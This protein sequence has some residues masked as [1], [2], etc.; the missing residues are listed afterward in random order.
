MKPKIGPL[1]GAILALRRQLRETQRG[2][3]NRLGASLRAYSYWE[4]GERTP[5]GGWLARLA[6]IAEREAAHK[7]DM[8][9]LFSEGKADMLQGRPPAWRQVIAAEAMAPRSINEQWAHIAIE[10]IFQEAP[11]TVQ[12]KVIEMIETWAGK[13]GAPPSPTRQV[14]TGRALDDAAA[15]ALDLRRQAA[16][17]TPGPDS[18]KLTGTKVALTETSRDE[19]ATPVHKRKER[20]HR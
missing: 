4:S 18:D 5:T 12:G 19:Q 16:R 14:R 6:A 20:L 3:A 13:Y 7:F 17:E 2:M 9:A 1:A 8:A 11:E 10:I 15:E